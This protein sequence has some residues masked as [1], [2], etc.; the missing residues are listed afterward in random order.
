MREG[1][2]ETGKGGRGEWG[3]EGEEAL[4]TVTVHPGQKGWNSYIYLE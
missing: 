2:G 3:A 4:G 1:P